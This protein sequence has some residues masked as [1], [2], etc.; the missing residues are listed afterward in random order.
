MAAKQIVLVTG[1]NTGIG[2]ETVK[3]LAQSSTPSTIL[4]GSRSLDNA[5]SA[6]KQLQY[7][8]PDTKSEIVPLQIDIESDE[9][10]EQCLKDVKSKYGKVD[11][12]VNNAGTKEFLY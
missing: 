9:S 8:V 5:A 11:A 2:Y 6:I 10:I 4:M 1:G 3:A 7:E 12:L